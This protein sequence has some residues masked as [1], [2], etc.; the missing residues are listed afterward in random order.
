MAKLKRE[1]VPWAKTMHAFPN[2]EQLLAYQ[3]GEQLD[4][5]SPNDD[6]TDQSR[7]ASA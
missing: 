4:D 7:S 3:F 1:E 6:P 2:R 5:N